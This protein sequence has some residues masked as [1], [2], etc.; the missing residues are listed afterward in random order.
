MWAY[1]SARERDG[2]EESKKKL[3]WAPEKQ[4]PLPTPSA[5]AQAQHRLVFENLLSHICHQRWLDAGDAD[6][7]W[8]F[9]NSNSKSRPTSCDFPSRQG[10]LLYPQLCPSECEVGSSMPCKGWSTSHF[11][12]WLHKVAGLSVV[13][14][15]HQSNNNLIAL[16]IY[17]VFTIYQVLQ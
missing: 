4:R 17:H 5:H 3:E 6:P 8:S 7:G 1:L 9:P 15:S 10:P 11:G 12:P 13:L 16:I 2:G 14:K